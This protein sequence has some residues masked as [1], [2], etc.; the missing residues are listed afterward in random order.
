MGRTAPSNQGAGSTSRGP[1]V[2]PKPSPVLPPSYTFQRVRENRRQK[3]LMARAT[4]LDSRTLFAIAV[5]QGERIVRGTAGTDAAG[6]AARRPS[7]APLKGSAAGASGAPDGGGCVSSGDGSRRERWMSDGGEVARMAGRRALTCRGLAVPGVSWRRPGS[8]A[9]MN[10]TAGRRARLGAQRAPESAAA[11]ARLG[12]E[13][14]PGLFGAPPGR[15]RAHTAA[16]R[17]ASCRFGQR[18]GRRHV[19]HRGTIRMLQAH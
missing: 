13:V 12:L 3:R 17:V 10:T 14:E 1:S 16:R 6:G 9:A 7:A 19:M 8:A 15:P 11:A 18:F 4:Q 5:E 2:E